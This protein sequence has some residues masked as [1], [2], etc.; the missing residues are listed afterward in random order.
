MEPIEPGRSW[1]A[2][3]TFQPWNAWDAGLAPLTWRRSTV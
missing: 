1:D 2:V 3:A